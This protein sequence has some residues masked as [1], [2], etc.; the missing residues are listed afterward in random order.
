MLQNL[1]AA[2]WV[3]WV[4]DGV[5][6]VVCIIFGIIAAKK[7]FITSL[8]T[9]I[10]TIVSLIVAICLVSSVLTWTNGI[11]GLQGVLRGTLTNALGG[12]EVFQTDVSNAGIHAA[13]AN[14]GLPGFLC[15][16]IIEQVGDST[17]PEGTTLAMLAGPALGDLATSLIC[18]IALFF[19]M[20]LLLLI[21]RG[22]INSIVEK[23]PLADALNGLLG[24][25]IGVFKGL[26]LVSLV[27]SIVSLIPAEGITAFFADCTV[28]GWLYFSNPIL[29]IL[30]WI[31]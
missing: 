7:G 16:M 25:A 20:K 9:L 19:I 29:S 1:C 12:L 8:F 2:T 13:L 27:L 22:I 18:G 4:V 6:A 10:S 24:F 23:I 15:D 21:V 17:I 3:N 11:F 5:V 26:L 14:K 28:T 31:I 30:S